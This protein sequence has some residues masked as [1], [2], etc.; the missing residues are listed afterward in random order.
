MIWQFGMTVW[1]LLGKVPAWVWGALAL[2]SVWYIDRTAHGNSRYEEGRETVLADLRQAETKAKQ[3]AWEA[4]TTEGEKGA[5]RARE[6]E[7][8]QDALLDVIKKAEAD[9]TSALDSLF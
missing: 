3:A 9:E 8:Q 1:R 7:A 5:V 4:I 6:F 2:V